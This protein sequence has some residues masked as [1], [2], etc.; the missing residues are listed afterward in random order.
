MR[1]PRCWPRATRSSTTATSPATRRCGSGSPSGTGSNRRASSSRR[2]RCPASRC[3]PRCC[4]PAAGA[5]SSRRPPTTGRFASSSGLGADITTVPLRR[6]R[7]RRRRARGA[8]CGRPAG[9]PLLDPDVPEPERTHVPRGDAPCPAR[10]GRALRPPDPR[11]RPVPPRAL[12]RRAAADAVRARPAA[13]AS[14]TQPRSRRSWRPACGSATWCSRPSSWRPSRRARCGTYL[15]PALSRRRCCSSSSAADSSRRTSSAR[16]TLL[17]ERRDAML[18]A[19]EQ[20]FGPRGASWSKPRRRL[21]RLA[22]PAGRHRRGRG[23]LDAA[24]EAGVAVVK[25]SDFFPHG[26]AASLL[27]ARVQLRLGRRAD[28]GDRA[29]SRR[30]VPAAAPV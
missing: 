25:G 9:V 16:G 21:L 6:R 10:A 30:A 5:R 1:A 8:G 19:L 12:R 3:S 2:A 11:G 17:R 26:R 22:R 7:A 29:A 4:S 28:R 24:A 20:H 15:S 23:R 14:S 18:D 13:R 27:P